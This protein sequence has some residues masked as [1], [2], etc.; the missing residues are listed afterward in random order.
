[1]AGFTAVE[2]LVGLAIAGCLAAALA[3]L[4][5][6]LQRGGETESDR[7]V[8][9]LQ[10]RVALARFERDLR[11]S[12]AAG[13]PFSI[14]GSLLEATPSQLVFLRRREPGSTPL[15]VEWEIVK[16]S[17]MRRWGPCPQEIP[18]S[19][20]HNLYADSKT[21]LDGVAGKSCLR[22]FTD[23]TESELP[24]DPGTLPLLDSVRLELVSGV[25]GQSGEVD[26][27]TLGRV[28]W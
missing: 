15:L 21:M 2:L 11:M 16:G 5:I 10:C 26:A 1:V 20:P 4:W 3:P 23:G 22:Y 9:Y 27:S 19:F 8:W 28:G 7:G 24:V 6:S 17:L 12:S 25:F 13:C 14:A 18:R